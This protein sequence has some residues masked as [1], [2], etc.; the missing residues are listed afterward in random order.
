MLG[1]RSDNV[2]HAEFDE[3]NTY[4][5]E[6]F[7]TTA[8]NPVNKIILKLNLSDH[9]SILTDS[10]VTPTKHG[11]MTKLYLSPYFIANCFISRIFKDGDGGIRLY[12]TC[13]TSRSIISAGSSTELSLSS[14]RSSF[15]GM[16]RDSSDRHFFRL[17]TWKISLLSESDNTF[18]SLQALSNL[19]YL[20]SGFM[21]YLWSRELDISNFGPIDR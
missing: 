19:Y 7:N 12:L 4:V 21:D 2:E 16:T 1:G 8:G 5:L 3:S 9:R 17:E 11:R 15:I 10:K 14:S 13:L 6:R 20:F 18:P